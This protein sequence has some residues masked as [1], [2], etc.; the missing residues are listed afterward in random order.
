MDS[1]SGIL[2]VPNSVLPPNVRLEIIPF[3]YAR[4][5]HTSLPAQREAAHRCR[6]AAE[7]GGGYGLDAASLTA[8]TSRGVTSVYLCVVCTEEWPSAICTARMSRVPA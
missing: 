5:R 4:G 7:V 6:W 3:P 8:R 2:L 1:G